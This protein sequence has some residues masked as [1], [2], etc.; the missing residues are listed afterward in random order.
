MSVS[1]SGVSEKLLKLDRLRKLLFEVMTTLRQVR[2]HHCFLCTFR[3]F[4]YGVLKKLQLIIR[5]DF[6][7]VSLFVSNIFTAL[8]VVVAHFWAWLPGAIVPWEGGNVQCLPRTDTRP[9]NSFSIGV[10]EG[11][12]A[13][14]WAGILIIIGGSKYSWW[15]SLI[16]SRL[17]I[18]LQVKV[19]RSLHSCV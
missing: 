4:C 8:G 14:E 16:F 9:A 13:H 10:S 12:R 19:V 5:V 7:F 6:F 17:L 11:G 1:C 3:Y 18:A 15:F 2:L